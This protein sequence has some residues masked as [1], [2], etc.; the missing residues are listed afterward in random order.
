MRNH[1]SLLHDPSLI[2]GDI[3]DGYSAAMQTAWQVTSY[4]D[5]TDIPWAS[6]ARAAGIPSAGSTAAFFQPP[7]TMSLATDATLNATQGCI[8]QVDCGREVQVVLN[9]SATGQ[10]AFYDYVAAQF[11]R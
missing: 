5:R 3:N 1:A 4:I 11:D 10:Q 9:F 8:K 6:A 2:W 7:T